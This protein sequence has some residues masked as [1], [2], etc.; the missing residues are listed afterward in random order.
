MKQSQA[1]RLCNVLRQDKST[2]PTKL[3]APLKSDFRDLIRE[4]GDLLGDVSVEI[5]DTPSCYTIMMVAKVA[6]FKNYG[7]YI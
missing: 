3:L 6:R 7:T 1:Q 4:Y 5:E 2:S